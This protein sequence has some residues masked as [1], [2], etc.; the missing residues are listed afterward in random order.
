MQIQINT[1]HNIEG[2]EALSTHIREVVTHALAHESAHITRVEVH[3]SDEN[4]PKSGPETMRCAMQA[5]L[6]R[7]QPLDVTCDAASLHQAIAGAAHKLAHLLAHTLGKQRDEK[8][9]RTDP[10]PEDPGQP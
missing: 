2:R 8:R 10:V 5:R 6:E 1:G 7:Q 3:A 9:Q 4:G